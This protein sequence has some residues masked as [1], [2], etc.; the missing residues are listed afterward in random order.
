MSFAGGWGVSGSLAVQG[1][2]RSSRCLS[3]LVRCRQ[4]RARIRS[5]VGACSP[6]ATRSNFRGSRPPGRPQT[7]LRP[8]SGLAGALHSKRQPALALGPERRPP[9]PSKRGVPVG[10]REAEAAQATGPG[11]GVPEAAGARAARPPKRP[12]RAWSRKAGAGVQPMQGGRGGPRPRRRLHPRLT[13]RRLGPPP[14]SAPYT[15]PPSCLPPA[16]ALR[17]RAAADPPLA[18]ST[19]PPVGLPST[20]RPTTAVYW[21]VWT[22]AGARA[23]IGLHSAPPQRCILLAHWSAKA[24]L[25]GRVG[26]RPWG[27]KAVAMTSQGFG[28]VIRGWER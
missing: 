23:G 26:K 20:P 15:P 9:R 13:R 5:R 24:H 27:N 3:G 6:P 18:G 1:V 25:I 10:L 14:P 8:T 11:P 7:G 16:P 4:P 28:A 21:A 12:P 22:R 19:C 2:P 17:R